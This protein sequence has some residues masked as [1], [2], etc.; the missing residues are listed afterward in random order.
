MI[1][2]ML[3]TILSIPRLVKE[4]GQIQESIGL[5][6]DKLREAQ[7]AHQ[8]WSSPLPSSAESPPIVRTFYET[9]VDWSTT[10][11]SKATLWELTGSVTEDRDEH[12]EGEVLLLL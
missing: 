2:D 5:L 8:V 11:R 10:W 12:F 9:K 6:N 1:V 3:L 4:V 7:T